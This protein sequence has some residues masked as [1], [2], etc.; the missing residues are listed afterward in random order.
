MGIL[1]NGIHGGF[2]N[3][4]GPL[5]G[6][7]VRKK[8]VVFALPH[9]SNKPDTAA[10]L[11][12]RAKFKLLHTCLMEFIELIRV[13]FRNVVDI[14]PLNAA[15]R[16]SYPALVLGGAARLQVDYSKLVLSSGKLQ[17]LNSL[18]AELIV[19]QRA[20]LFS[21]LAAPQNRLNRVADFVCMSVYS[22][23]RSIAVTS[24][25]QVRR[26]ELSCN[27]ELPGNFL[28]GTLH[29]YVSVISADN[30]DVSNSVYLN[31]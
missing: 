17:P 11:C 29:C 24:I 12:Q 5:I 21:W 10:Q 9:K 16:A 19:D 28:P 27:L 23:E 4:T 25:G 15:F 3:K 7:I 14:T 20:V 22:A 6:R 31:L 13:G 30:K 1:Y 26:G 2:V 8:N 18:S